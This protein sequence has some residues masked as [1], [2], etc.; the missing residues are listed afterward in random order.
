MR[1]AA[2]LRNY[3]S[4]SLLF[5]KYLFEYVCVMAEEDD[6]TKFRSTLFHVKP[7]EALLA[8]QNR[9][10]YVAEIS[11]EIDST[12]SHTTKLLKRFEEH[13]LV[14]SERRGRRNFFVLTEKGRELASDLSDIESFLV[15][16]SA[17]DD[18]VETGGSL[19]RCS[20]SRP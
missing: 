18:G 11:T 10:L 13:D 6:L 9:R 14:D 5:Y 4:S 12:R 7:Y 1:S 17:F 15:P 16:D 3:L 19:E 8:L 2:G 20:R